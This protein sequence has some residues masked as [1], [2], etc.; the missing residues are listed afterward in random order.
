M[1]DRYKQLFVF[2]PDY[3]IESS[4]VELIKG[5]ILFDC[6]EKTNVLQLKLCNNSFSKLETLK[7]SIQCFIEETTTYNME[8][9]Y[10]YKNLCVLPQ[11][12]FGEDVAIA[13]PNAEIS[14]VN[15]KLAN[16]KL[17][18]EKE[19]DISQLVQR[20]K[21]S[22]LEVDSLEKNCIKELY[23]ITSG[24]T[25]LFEKRYMPIFND[26]IW[27]CT[28]GKVNLFSSNIC[29]RCSRQKKILLERFNANYLKNSI[30]EREKNK[31]MLEQQALIEAKNQ[32]L[33][34]EKR[35]RIVLIS[36]ATLLFLVI[37]SV[38]VSKCWIPEITYINATRLIDSNTYEQALHELDK[39]PLY[40][41]S[42]DLKWFSYCR[43]YQVNL[44]DNKE[45]STAI[46]DNALLSNINSNIVKNEHGKALEEYQEIVRK[47][48]TIAA[49]YTY[50]IKIDSYSTMRS[51][52][53]K[54]AIAC[55]ILASINKDLITDESLLNNI[56]ALEEDL[57]SVVKL[58]PYL[59]YLDDIDY[60]VKNYN[61]LS[62]ALKGF[63]AASF[64]LSTNSAVSQTENLIN[65]LEGL[66]PYSSGEYSF[67]FNEAINNLLSNLEKLKDGLHKNNN[68]SL[69]MQLNSTLEALKSVIIINNE[70]VN[71][72]TELNNLFNDIPEYIRN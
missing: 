45:I 60:L 24:E 46:I 9:N 57:S 64:F 22:L 32:K 68:F 6:I 39:I 59:K 29:T 14:R 2:E 3:W 5:A 12:T 33:L 65:Q 23:E 61:Y 47:I 69:S 55:D 7:I 38:V 1:I 70:I 58:K 62:E 31:L 15:I 13:L 53:N 66:P 27:V 72:Q 4:P 21:P 19:L 34:K 20:Q 8:I 49:N 25:F 63:G 16:V 30:Q 48:Y 10:L 67:A 26:E 51:E 36:I 56:V 71:T 41:N 18:G 35:I 42:Q 43:L 11:N 40:K 50:D 37:G 44:E 28:C 17:A 52:M 54:I